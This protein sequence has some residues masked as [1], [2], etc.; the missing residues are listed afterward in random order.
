MA[1][2][3]HETAEQMRVLFNARG[4]SI[5]KNERWLMPQRHDQASIKKA[6]V[7]TW[8]ETIRDLL[9][10]EFMVDEAGRPLNDEQFDESL[11]MPF[12]RPSALEALNK[13]K[14]LSVPLA[15]EK[16]ISQGR[17]KAVPI[18]QRC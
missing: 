8:K 5:S 4:G 6:G 10:R 2:A 1:D 14:G 7:E 15:R 3:W 11:L 16:A 13:A 17:R 12:T 18:F 9:D